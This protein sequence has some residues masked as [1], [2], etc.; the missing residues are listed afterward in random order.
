M[1]R[2]RYAH[3]L[4]FFG[5]IILS[6]IFWDLLLFSIGFRNLVRK[7]R[8]ERYRRMAAQF[9]LEAIKMGGVMIKIGQF[10]SARLDV[11]PSVITD[12][13]AGLQDEVR[14]EDPDLLFAFAEKEFNLPLPE[15]YS[16]I[17]PQPLAA[18]SIGQVHRA[19]LNISSERAD[20]GFSEVIIK[21][22]RPDIEKIVAVD[23]AALKVV[24][25]W[26][27]YYPPIRKRA[28]IPAI[29]DEFERSFYEELD[30]LNEGKNAERFAE[31]FSDQP[32][33]LVPEVVWSHTTRRVLTLEYIDA[34]KITDYAKIEACGIDR[35]QV[36]DQLFDTY[37]Q[38]IF[39]DRFFHADPHPG[40]LFV[41]PVSPEESGRI[42]QN[43][44]L[45]FIDF[46]MAG[47]ISEN[48]MTTLREILVGVGTRDAHRIIQAYQTLGVLLPNTDVDLLERATNRVFE[49]FWGK[50][51]GELRQ[52]HQE[53][54]KA[55]FQEFGALIYEMPFQIPQNI[56]LLARSLG[57]LS[58]ICS[59]LN[60]EF[61]VWKN[62]SPY[63]QKLVNTEGGSQWRFWLNEIG[64]LV[65]ILTGLPKRT[66]QLISRIEQGNLEIKVPETDR[67]IKAL[68]VGLRR[69]V[70]AIL[71]IGFLSASVQ[72]YLAQEAP[73]AI[74]LAIGALITFVFVL[75][76]R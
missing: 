49:H 44:R 2:R 25:R 60:T 61:N 1:F 51:M 8:S 73:I 3:I 66:D 67:R 20:P 19:R 72:F 22:Q 50:T 12:E 15:Q 63:V 35:E 65:T 70:A 11:L 9:R 21:I 69:L 16:F 23:L 42:G 37:L 28:N 4:W 57:I 17:D 29:L 52:M 76:A 32:R 74:G 27:M 5:K 13:L 26:L 31:N 71:F 55:F 24:A 58:G 40:N 34:I 30:Y 45:V 38:Q 48:L 39:E 18:A 14:P 68:E 54:A 43:W 47:V 33:I 64:S 46:G 10:L 41:L 56:L 36:S 75:F 59:G 62:I 7:T 6:F 53:E